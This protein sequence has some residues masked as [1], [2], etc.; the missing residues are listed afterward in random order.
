MRVLVTGATGF[1]GGH[2]VRR[3]NQRG[4]QVLAT[5]RNLIK[6]RTLGAPFQAADL[7]NL[8]QAQAVCRGQDAVVHCAAFSSPWGEEAD[9]RLHNEIVTANL[10][11]TEVQRFVHISSAGVYFRKDEGLNVRESDPLPDSNDHP[12]LD[13]KRRAEDLVRDTQGWVILR[14]RAIYG[15]G[16]TAI[17]PRIVRLLRKG[18]LPV[19]GGGQNLASL[20]HVENLALAVELALSGPD[21]QTF[22][23]ADGEPVLLWPLLQEVAS[24]LGFPPIKW[25]IPGSVAHLLTIG[26]EKFYGL[27]LPD[28]EPPLTRYTLSLLMNNQTLCLEKIRTRLRY[29]PIHSTRFGVQTTL[30]ALC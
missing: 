18:M 21:C 17:L 14:P 15:P 20:T 22:N 5:G 19:I 24:Q 8:D 16:D 10:L 26:L 12:Y 28:R 1:L 11:S 2:V 27:L 29:E 13:S 30:A 7:C 3:L 6:G 9:F 25:R 4:F 23:V